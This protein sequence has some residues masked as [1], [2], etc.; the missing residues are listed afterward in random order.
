MEWNILLVA[1]SIRFE[2]K[3]QMSEEL[4]EFSNVEHTSYRFII[5]EIDG[6]K[7]SL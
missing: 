3:K 1:Q 5:I 2:T 6:S 7:H 4:T